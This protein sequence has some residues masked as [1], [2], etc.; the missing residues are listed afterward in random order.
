MKSNVV[1]IGIDVGGTHTKA[2]AIDNNTHKIIGKYSVK[3]THDH[4]FGVATGVINA[5]KGCLESNDIKPEQVAF[6]AHS[7]TQATNALLEGDVAHVGVIGVVDKGIEGYLGKRQVQLKDIDLGTGRAIKISNA[8]INKKDLTAENIKN[9]INELKALGV[10]VLVTSRAFG[11]DDMTDETSVAEVAK[12]MKIPITIASDI[13][14]LYGLTRRTK[15]GAINASILPK[16]LEVAN[17]TEKSVRNAG[18]TVPLMI[19]RGDGGSMDIEEMKKRPIL[20]MLSGPA[21]SVMGSLMYLRISNG[22]YFE[23]GGTSTNIGVI[24]NGRPA[25]DYSVVDGH[26]T[27]VTSIDVRVLGVAGGSMIRGNK[28]GVVD[29]GPRS[30]HI[31]GMDYAVFTPEEEIVDPKIEFFSPKE[32]DPNDYIAI[33]LK[34]GKRITITNTC[35]ANILGLI[36]PEQ[37]SYG[38][39]NSARKAMQVVADYMKTTVEDVAAQILEKSFR[40]IEPVILELAQKYKLDKSQISL[41]GVGG[42]ASSLIGYCADK[43]DV[44]YSIPE[45]AEVISSIGVALSMIRESVERVIPNPRPQDIKNIRNEVMTKVIENGAD[46]SSIDIHIEI[47]STTSKLIAIATGAAEVKANDLL[48]ECTEQEAKELAAKDMNIEIENVKLKEKTNHFYVFDSVIKGKGLIRILDKKGFIKVQ[49]NNGST[50]KVKAKD[51]QKAVKNIYEDLTVYKAD[52]VLRPDFYLCVGPRVMDFDSGTELKQ[53][54]MLMD[55][56]VQDVQEDD[57]ILVIGVKNEI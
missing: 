38:N 17:S 52:S 41:I 37:F 35:A 44:K 16:M 46:P 4:Q 14:K 24:K 49:R 53:N 40:K 25:I 31:A 10:Q 11:V 15:T 39:V 28:N 6:V 26:K 45:N 20:T 57:D 56:I 7:T 22:I 54:L 55:V 13:T 8:I 50:I 3:T 9:T 19:M 23:V 30:A 1:R 47:D 42:G 27:Y 43:M 36:K 29:A 48:K 18:V 21:A 2:V 5:F 12:K 51:Y 34:S 32:G 33:R